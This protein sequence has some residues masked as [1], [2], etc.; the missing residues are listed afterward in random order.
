MPTESRDMSFYFF[1][2]D[3]N[4][5]FLETPIFIRNTG[6]GDTQ[7]VSTTDFASIRTQLGQQG[8]WKDFETFEGTYSHFR[9]IPAGQL[10]PGQKQ[11]LVQDIE[12][13]IA[14]PESKWQAPSWRLFVYA[15]EQQRPLSI[16]T[17]RGHSRE[18]IK[19]GVRVLFDHGLIKKEPNY[20]TIYAVGNPDIQAELLDS[21]TDEGGKARVSALTDPTSALKRIAIRNTVDKA[22]EVYG[23]EPPHRFGM[24]DDDPKNVDLIIKAM[25]DCKKK[26]LDKRFFVIDTHLGEMV[27]LE[28]FPVDH[29]V[30]GR[31][32]KHEAVG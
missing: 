19:A 20:L 15:C 18:T 29:P 25:C 23:K 31:A 17:A 9:D 10:G 32:E 2:L 8:P 12:E 5:L 14:G 4:T 30:T 1:D 7:K 13:A 6:N 3:D 11:Y 24:S 22:L 28:V 21:L 16:V 26:Y 27:K